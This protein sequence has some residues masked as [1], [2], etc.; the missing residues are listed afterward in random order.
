MLLRTYKRFK[1]LFPH[2]DLRDFC[3]MNKTRPKFK[4]NYIRFDYNSV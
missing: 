1:N 4:L 2:F 3:L